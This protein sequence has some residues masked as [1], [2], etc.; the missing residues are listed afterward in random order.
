MECHREEMN[1]PFWNILGGSPA[2]VNWETL[3][4][5]PGQEALVASSGY[6]LKILNGRHPFVC[7]FQDDFLII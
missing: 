6:K 7:F 4:G 3:T 2:D 1:S 5:N